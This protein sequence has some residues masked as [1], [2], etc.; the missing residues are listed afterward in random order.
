MIAV[1]ASPWRSPWWQQRQDTLPLVLRQVGTPCGLERGG[2]RSPHGQG[3]RA[4]GPPRQMAAFGDRLMAPPPAGPVQPE[5]EA[6]GRLGQGQQQP[7]DLGHRE[8]DQGARRSWTPFFP[9]SRSGAAV[10]WARVTSR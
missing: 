9:P 6:L 1:R 3:D 2:H 4:P 10:A 7:T 8:R 5:A